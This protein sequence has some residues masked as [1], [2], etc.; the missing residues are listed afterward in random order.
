[1]WALQKKK[2]VWCGEI[3]KRTGQVWVYFS[4]QSISPWICENVKNDEWSVNRRFLWLWA[5]NNH[6]W[7]RLNSWEQNRGYYAGTQN[8]LRTVTSIPPYWLAVLWTIIKLSWL[9]ARKSHTPR[10][11]QVKVSALQFIAQRQNNLCF[12]TAFS[13]QD[14]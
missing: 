10:N 5:I 3:A 7:I 6:K 2:K 13:V 8:R 11:R 14:L 4:P 9:I 1:M 12:I